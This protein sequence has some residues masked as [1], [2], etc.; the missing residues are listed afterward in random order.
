MSARSERVFLPMLRQLDQELRVPVPER[1]RILRE[2]EFDLEELR[3]RLEGEG[4]SREEARARALEM[5][6]PDGVTLREL[7]RL[8]TPTYLRLTR[9]L[10]GDR[11]RVLERGALAL[12]TASVLL[13]EATLLAGADVL[14]EPSPFIWPVLGVGALLFAAIAAKVFE[15]WIKRDHR[16]PDRGLGVILA[17]AALSMGTAMIGSFLDLYRV[18]SEIEGAP[19]QASTLM[20]DWLV[21]SSGLGAVAILVAMAGALAWFVLT[22]W[23]ALVSGARH[24]LLGIDGSS[25]PTTR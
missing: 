14:R 15:L 9:R 3:S 21:R 8:H 24:D 22:H 25:L 2:L 11:L 6:A 19:R 18:A 5:L 23:L 4:R 17:L 7:S 12:A 13:I 16:T 20:T 1:V 10:R